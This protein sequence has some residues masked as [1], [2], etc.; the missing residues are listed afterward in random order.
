MCLLKY[1]IIFTVCTSWRRIYNVLINSFQSLC[2]TISTVWW[3]W[4]RIKL[5]LNTELEQ[6]INLWPLVIPLSKSKIQGLFEFE[7]ME[8]SSAI[9]LYSI[10]HSHTVNF[11]QPEILSKNWQIYRERIDTEQWYISN[12]PTKCNTKKK[13]IHAAWN[14]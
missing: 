9:A 7:N 12:E 3:H 2:T 5:G 10:E 4:L 14:L 11:N 8:T 1:Q 13:A 6:R